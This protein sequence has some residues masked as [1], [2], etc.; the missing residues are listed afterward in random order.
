MVHLSQEDYNDD[1]DLQIMS[2]VR[3]L[4]GLATPER[5]LSAL[6]KCVTSISKAF[7][8]LSEDT[9]EVTADDLL[10]FTSFVLVSTYFTQNPTL[11]LIW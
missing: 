2:R 9:D 3:T 11:D 5:K 4:H 6:K 8:L 10:Q 1:Q 7:L